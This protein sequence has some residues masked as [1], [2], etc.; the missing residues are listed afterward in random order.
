[1]S[2]MRVLLCASLLLFALASAS[3]LQTTF[4]SITGSVTDA[5]GAVVPRRREVS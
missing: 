2:Q 1:M 5:T 3:Y 4:A